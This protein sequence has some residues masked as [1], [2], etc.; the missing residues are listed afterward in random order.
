M[1]FKKDMPEERKMAF[2]AHS[3]ILVIAEGS[4]LNHTPTAVL[5]GT[6]TSGRK[7]DGF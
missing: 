3:T 5:K 6:R 1:P 4:P 2:N 7:E